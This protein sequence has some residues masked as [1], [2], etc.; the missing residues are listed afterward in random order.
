MIKGVTVGVSVMYSLFIKLPLSSKQ[1]MACVH[2]QNVTKD[3]VL[4][5]S[6]SER[7]RDLFPDVL[8]P[9]VVQPFQSERSRKWFDHE[10]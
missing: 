1:N 4:I 9:S 10:S 2:G 6:N 8:F 7:D 5:S 3:L